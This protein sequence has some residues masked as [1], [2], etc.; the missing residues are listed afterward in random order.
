VQLGGQGREDFY[1]TGET[2]F[3]TGSVASSSG[4]TDPANDTM[5]NQTL[6]SPSLQDLFNGQ[7][8][9]AKQ[10]PLYWQPNGP[11]QITEISSNLRGVLPQSPTHSINP[12]NW[13]FVK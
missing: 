10:L 5:I 7:D 12:E 11:Y 9:L 8:Y 3:T 4:Y 1:P 13:Y 2:L 6:T